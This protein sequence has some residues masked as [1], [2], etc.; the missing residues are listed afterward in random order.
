MP[1]AW[2]SITMKELLEVYFQTFLEFY[3]PDAARR[4]TGA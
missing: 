2:A 4:W 1:G 3:F